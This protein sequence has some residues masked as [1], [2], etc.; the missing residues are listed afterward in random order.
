MIIYKWKDFERYWPIDN[1]LF[2]FFT[3]RAG[4]VG[5]DRVGRRRLADTGGTMDGWVA[6]DRTDK[7]PIHILLEKKNIPTGTGHGTLAY[8]H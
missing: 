4:Q 7:T 3:Q 6:M 1:N 2:M 8:I 5:S